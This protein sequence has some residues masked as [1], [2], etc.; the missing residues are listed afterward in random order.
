MKRFTVSLWTAAIAAVLLAGSAKA[1]PPEWRYSWTPSKFDIPSDDS[2]T[3]TI[4]LTGEND[5]QVFGKSDI[6]ATNISVKSDANPGTPD[7]FRTTGDLTFTLKITDV[8]SN[9]NHTFTF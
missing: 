8:A 7:E 6:T 9:T 5:P 4:H 1:A 3:S 2:P